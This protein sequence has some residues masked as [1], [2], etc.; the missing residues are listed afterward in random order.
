M[1][2]EWQF[3]AV[4]ER[5]SLLERMITA[6]NKR[7]GA[8]IEVM[9]LEMGTTLSFSREVQMPVGIGHLE[10]A[11]EAL[12]AH[13]FERPSLRGGSTL[14]DEPV[15]VVGMITPWNWP[16]NQIM[17]KV[18]PA[19]AAGC[20]IVL[21]PS[22]YSPL[23]AIMLAEVVDEAGCPPG[24]FNL[25]NGDGPVVGEAISAHPD[26]HMVSFTGSTRAGKLVTKSAANSIKRV[27]LE[28]G[29]KSPNLFFADADLDAVAQ[30]S[31]DACF[32]NN[33][34]SCDAASRLLVDRKVY[35]DV[36]DRVAKIGDNRKVDDPMKEGSHIGPVVNKKQFEHVQRLI[37]VGI[38]GGTRLA[39]G[40][41]GR[42]AGFNKGYYIRPTLFADVT[43][44]MYMAQ[45]DVFGPVL[46]ILP[47]DTEEEA[48]KIANDTPYGLA[49]YIQST[50]QERIDRVSRKLRAGIVSVNG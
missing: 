49:A 24:V 38:D 39:A 48:I 33:G 20:T 50:D 32:I 16:V 41:L 44:D 34:R 1:F 9:S 22:E 46:A 10:A 23:S 43:N 29:G 15:G 36:V 13:Q 40:A 26:I 42:P 30:V 12:K 19:L 27:T 4:D 5:V 25:V 18:T 6:Y 11:I 45:Q 2:D 14:V 28:L 37:Q 47:F 17:I 3:S 31:V 21:K 8:F 7:A 35:D